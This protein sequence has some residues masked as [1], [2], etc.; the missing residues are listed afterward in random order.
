[1]HYEITSEFEAL[2]KRYTHEQRD[3]VITMLFNLEKWKFCQ[4]SKTWRRMVKGGPSAEFGNEEDTVVFLREPHHGSQAFV[5][6]WFRIY[7]MAMSYI[8]SKNV[9]YHEPTGKAM[10]VRAQIALLVACEVH[11]KDLKDKVYQDQEF[12]S[13]LNLDI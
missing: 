5:D 11:F 13:Y 4:I 6:W 10:P 3:E 9:Y 8:K 1:M 2:D 7:S 12:N